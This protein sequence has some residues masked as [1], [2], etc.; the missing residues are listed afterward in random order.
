MGTGRP[1][2]YKLF[3]D[4]ANITSVLIPCNENYSKLIGKNRQEENKKPILESKNPKIQA[5][6]S[7]SK[8]KT[9]TKNNL[10]K[11]YVSFSSSVFSPKDIINL[12]NVSPNTATNYIE[13]LSE[14]NVLDKVAGAGQ[15][16]YRFKK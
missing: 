7:N 10:D 13:K 15:S 9:A 5:L 1:I 14:L 8:Y 11:I 2:Y 6:I 16:K 4:D 12:L 3:D